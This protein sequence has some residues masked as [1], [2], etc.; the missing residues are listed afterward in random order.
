V[1]LN[2]TRSNIAMLQY[3]MLERAQGKGDKADWVYRPDNQL[4]KEIKRMERF[5]TEQTPGPLEY[6][7]NSGVFYM[8]F[9]KRDAALGK[10]GIVMPIEHYKTVSNDPRCATGK[11]GA[12]RI[13]YDSLAGR[14]M[15]ED[16]F[17]ALLRSGYIGPHADT[18]QHFTTLIHAIVKSDRA[19][20]G[21]I[22][23]TSAESSDDDWGD[24]EEC[25]AEVADG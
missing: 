25:W 7:L 19:I 15:R 21:A 17:L 4:A 16:T 6:R 9:V 11:K 2:L 5:D 12:V 14:Y 8:K 3:K 22:A 20:V 23:Q 13:S 18:T 10:G 1:Y 24:A